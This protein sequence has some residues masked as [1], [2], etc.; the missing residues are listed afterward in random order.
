MVAFDLQ[1]LNL[2]NQFLNWVVD[3]IWCKNAP[4]VVHEFL[5]SKQYHFKNVGFNDDDH[6]FTCNSFS[7]GVIHLL[8]DWKFFFVH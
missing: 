8:H 3:L 7:F 5:P 1:K 4:K 6:E 2:K